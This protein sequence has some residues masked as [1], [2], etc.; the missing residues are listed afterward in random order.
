MYIK[1][2]V[3]LA[4]DL[5]KAYRPIFERDVPPILLHMDVW[6]QNILVDKQG[7]MTGLIDFDRALW[8]DP[9]IEFAVLDYCGIS[10]TSFWDGYEGTRPTSPDSRDRRSFYLLYEIQKYIPICIWRRDNLAEAEEYKN[11]SL[12]LLR[13][14]ERRLK[15]RNI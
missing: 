13:G 5:F 1:G 4:L 14:L 3:S 8:G 10:A 11:T 12:L 9:E 6:D 15:E 7:K 2:E